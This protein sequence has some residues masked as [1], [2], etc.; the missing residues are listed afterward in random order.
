MDLADPSL[1]PARDVF[2]VV[3]VYR[4]VL[5]A[6]SAAVGMKEGVGVGEYPFLYFASESAALV[7]RTPR[8]E[9]V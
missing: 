1:L 8:F 3:V 5:V 6:L 4:M 2:V 9:K 7:F